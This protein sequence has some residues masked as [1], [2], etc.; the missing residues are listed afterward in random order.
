ELESEG[1]TDESKRLL[2][3][4]EKAEPRDVYL[5]LTWTGDAGLDLNVEE[6]LGASA[7]AISPRT[8]YGGAVV[9]SGRGKNPESVYVCPLGFS[10][11]YQVRIDILYNDQSNP[12][13]TA[14]LEI[15]TH[16]GSPEE[17][18]ETR[19]IPIPLSQP[20][21]VH[22]ENGRRQ[23]V[24]PFEGRTVVRLVPEIQE[25]PEA[26]SGT[27]GRSTPVIGPETSEAADLLRAPDGSKPKKPGTI[28]LAPPQSTTKP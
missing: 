16:E 11:D 8:V 2:D 17:K 14:T 4:L 27:S 13:T 23:K 21:V 12:V 19:Q 25:S 7:T 22:L 10:G 18:K 20:V 1:R 24:L 9:K 5:R 28:Q 26:K 3:R 15:I 6:P